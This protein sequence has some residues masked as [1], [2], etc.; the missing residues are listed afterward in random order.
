M[1]LYMFMTRARVTCNMYDA[2]SYF[3]FSHKYVFKID[4][5]YAMSK[6]DHSTSIEFESRDKEVIV[7]PSYFSVNSFF[8]VMHI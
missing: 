7:S 3:C 2:Y 4:V 5:I 1:T 6:F 8:F